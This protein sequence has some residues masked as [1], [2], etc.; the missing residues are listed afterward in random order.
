MNTKRVRVYDNNGKTADRY[1][2]LIKSGK[3]WEVYTMGENPSNPL[4]I[5]QYSHNT[6]RIR[7][8]ISKDDKPVDNVPIEVEK[9]I[10]ERLRPQEDTEIAFYE[11]R[12]NNKIERYN[13]YE[14][15]KRNFEIAV[16]QSRKRKKIIGSAIF[17]DNTFMEILSNEENK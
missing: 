2:I 17:N 11:L 1:T 6:K 10:L 13:R 14:D 15:M 12:I 7:D 9:A 4:G 8:V 16:N 3:E 5:N